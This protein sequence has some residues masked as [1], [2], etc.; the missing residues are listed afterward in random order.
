MIR[1]AAAILY[2]ILRAGLGGSKPKWQ[3]N[4]TT[5]IVLT[6]FYR[7]DPIVYSKVKRKYSRGP[8][9]PG[10]LLL[11]PMETNTTCPP[12]DPHMGAA[13]KVVAGGKIAIGRERQSTYMSTF[14]RAFAIKSRILILKGL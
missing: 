5:K 2:S 9:F 12:L 3:N 1:A 11:I 13:F 8:F 10:V 6:L 4:L 14:N 7:G